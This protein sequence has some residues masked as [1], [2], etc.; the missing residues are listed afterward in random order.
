MR[1]FEKYFYDGFTLTNSQDSFSVIENK[2]K[3]KELILLFKENNNYFFRDNINNLLYYFINN[4]IKYNLPDIFV[5]IIL[6]NEKKIILHERFLKINNF[7]NI[8]KYNEMVLKNENLNSNHFSCIQTA[9]IKDCEEIY[10]FF[11]K[12]FDKR[13]VFYYDLKKLKENIKQILIYKENEKIHGALIYTKNINTTFLD[14]IAID[15][16]RTIYNNSISYALFSTFIYINNQSKSYKLF[17]DNTN[18][19]A[20]EF[21]KKCGFNFGST[22]LLFYTNNKNFKEF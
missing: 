3:S 1:E 19:H 22:Q 18:L 9:Q 6:K 15:K 7:N 14:F 10:N 16:K 13:F 4:E 5:K 11:T 21:Y 2:I 12:F 20:I 8:V 17:V